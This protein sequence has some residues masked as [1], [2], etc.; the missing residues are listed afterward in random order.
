MRSDIVYF[1]ALI[2]WRKEELIGQGAYG[3]IHL[4]RNVTTREK[5]AVK[6]VEITRY[7]RYRDYLRLVRIIK[8]LEN[9]KR[10][11]EKLDHPNIVR[12]LWFEQSEE[13]FS[14]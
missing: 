3:P 8:A 11:L 10:I 7:Q 14:T 1:V 9:E 4:A 5:M 13:F 12:Y 6:D 2:D